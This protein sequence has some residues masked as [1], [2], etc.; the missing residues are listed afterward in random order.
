[1]NMEDELSI[2]RKSFLESAF[3]DAY[4]NEE[5]DMEKDKT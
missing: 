2:K 4:N 5:K 3:N 1:M